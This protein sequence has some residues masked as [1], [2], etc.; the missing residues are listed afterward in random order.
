[1]KM[2]REK[3]VRINNA[4]SDIRIRCDQSLCFF[5]I[6]SESTAQRFSISQ[7]MY[8]LCVWVVVGQRATLRVA[9]LRKLTKP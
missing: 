6:S 3:T 2:V 7:T 5:Q 8:I 9:A 4:I 1:M